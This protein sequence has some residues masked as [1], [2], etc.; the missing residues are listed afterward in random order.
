[1]SSG[2][3]GAAF[4]FA[5]RRCRIQPFAQSHHFALRAEALMRLGDQAGAVSDVATALAL[6]P[7]DLQANRRMLA[8]GSDAQKLA[9]ASKLVSLDDDVPTLRQALAI[10]RDAKWSAAGGVRT[11]DDVIT[12][13]A[14]WNGVDNPVLTLAGGEARRSLMLLS[15]ADHPLAGGAFERVAG[16]SLRRPQSDA[17]QTVKLILHGRCFLQVACAPN[18]SGDRFAD[19]KRLAGSAD[20]NAV[21][22]IVPVYGDLAATKDCLESL[23]PEI[24][25]KAGRQTIVV[26]DATPEPEL[27]RFVE[28]FCDEAGFTLLI[29]DSNLGFAGSVNRAL[30]RVSDGDVLL[31][32]ADTVVPPGFIDRMVEIAASDRSIGTITPLSN[33]GEFT[34]FPV[35]FECNPLPTHAEALNLDKIASELN[36]G[37]VIDLPN[38]IGFCMLVTRRC[39]D[40][41]GGLS[42]AYQRG[43]LEDVDLCL[44]A[45]EQGFRNVCA[46]SIF[47]AH[48]GSRS[49]GAH[50]RSLVVRN[51][52]IAEAK[53]AGYRQECALF[54]D[55]DPLRDARAVIERKLAPADVDVLLISGDGILKDVALERAR[56][57]TAAGQ[58]TLMLWVSQQGTHVH[59]NTVNADMPHSLAFDVNHASGLDDLRS[60][61]TATSFSSVEIVE[62]RV[63]SCQLSGM[64]EEFGRPLRVLTADAGLLCPR[65]TLR[66][67][68]GQ[69]CTSLASD[70]PCEGC[71]RQDRAVVVVR[72]IDWRTRWR[73]STAEINPPCDEA[74]E[75]A[76]FLMS[77]RPDKAML[78]VTS[79]AGLVEHGGSGRIALMTQGSSLEEFQLMR[80]F[81]LAAVKASPAQEFIVVGAS[82]DDLSLMAVG[83]AFVTGSLE[84]SDYAALLERYEIGRAFLPLPRP[85]FGH[86]VGLAARKL[87]MPLA[88]FD[89]SFGR[90]VPEDGD[91]AIDPRSSVTDIVATVARWGGF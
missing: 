19:S 20:S 8:W 5:D 30:A 31:L 86:P 90:R 14:V 42:G 71:T 12:G 49:F 91:L 85:L 59:V 11:L 74:N 73:A 66:K 60:Y 15:E 16:F 41:I 44:R 17:G 28:R 55:A 1:M 79:S 3:F 57:L 68:D 9:A 72:D 51:I 52:S 24:S 39:L 75:F 35:P 6:S 37:K 61:L 26:N 21:T 58:K 80:Q 40:A 56:R 13:W 81:L 64:F 38:G 34:S 33:N 45:R 25:G 54:M 48:H 76:E 32:N 18:A 7:D 27:A 43:Y 63:M 29:N 87:G 89:W 23:K 62:P 2:D 77:P 47:V 53:F 36:R 46:P 70:T 88:Y 78:P 84:I 10:L 22:V 50:K 67:P 4:M 82:A 83:N 69:F 65:G